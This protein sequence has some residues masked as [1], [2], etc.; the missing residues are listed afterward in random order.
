MTHID[1]IRIHFSGNQHFLLN[2]CLAFVMFGVALHI[3]VDDFKKV[4]RFPKSLLIGITSQWL[5]F[6]I[7]TIYLIHL[8]PSVI[9]P[10]VAL[11]MLLVA[12]CPGGN[13]SNLL[14]NIAKGNAALSVSLSAIVMLSSIVLMPAVFL[15]SSHFVPATAPLLESIDADVTEILYTFFTILA[16]PLISGMTFNHVLPQ[17]SEKI[18]KPVRLVSVMIFIAFI[19]GAFYMNIDNFKNYIHLVAM[20]VIAHNLIG[21]SGGYLWSRWHRLPE[22]DARAISIETGIQNAGFGLGLVLLFFPR[23]GGMQ[24]VVAAWAIWDM[25]S[26]LFLAWFWNQKTRKQTAVAIQ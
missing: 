21:M 23:L 11:G 12:S 4:S 2:I 20:L 15:A 16:F 3:S 1:D 24:L 18:K 6:P 22:A 19:L 10:S 17:V 5:V 7:L 26:G 8:W 9:S 25:I 13:M 14:T